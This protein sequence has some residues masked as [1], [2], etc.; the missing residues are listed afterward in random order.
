MGL[1]CIFGLIEHPA[2]LARREDRIRL[3][4]PIRETPFLLELITRKSF[5]V[6]YDTTL[7]TLTMCRFLVCT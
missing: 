3:A 6:E 7:P 2:F 4:G 5:F 1:L